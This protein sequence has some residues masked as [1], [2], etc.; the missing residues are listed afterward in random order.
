MKLSLYCD[1]AISVTKIIRPRKTWENKHVESE[2]F[3]GRGR[4]LTRANVHLG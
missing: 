3:K 1:D 4:D 2:I